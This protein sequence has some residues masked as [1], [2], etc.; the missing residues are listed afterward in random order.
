MAAREREGVRAGTEERD[1]GTNEERGIKDGQGSPAES[2]GEGRWEFSF[3][4]LR[5]FACIP[6]DAHTSSD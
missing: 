2:E 3:P 4:L 5:G 1:R 6:R